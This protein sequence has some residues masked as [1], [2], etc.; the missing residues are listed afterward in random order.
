MHQVNHVNVVRT[1]D[2]GQ[3]GANTYFTMEYLQGRGL[4]VV[5][6]KEAPLPIERVLKFAEQLALGLDAIHSCDIIHRD[7]KPANIL[8]LDKDAVKITDFGVARPKS[9]HL[10]QHGGV[11]GTML[12]MAPEC[13]LGKKATA[14]VDAY[15]LGII[16]FEML[17]GRPPFTADEPTAIMMMHVEKR[18]PSPHD[19]RPDV[20]VWLNQ[21]VMRLLEKRAERR[22]SP[23]LL[24]E[25]IAARRGDWRDAEEGAKE[26]TP[27]PHS[28]PARAII[29]A[30][31]NRRDRASARR[32]AMRLLPV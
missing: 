19:L 24:A 5:L 6:A 3:D 1:F 8:V 11:F 2:V 20:P 12:Y 7:L 27:D 18:A 28:R 14:A 23:K 25:C 10:T 13:V 29:P 26:A 17:T 9:S 22:I 16:I 21:L 31:A 30:A 15:S 32:R 4:D